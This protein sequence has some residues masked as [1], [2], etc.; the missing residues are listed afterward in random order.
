MQRADSRE[1]KGGRLFGDTMGSGGMLCATHN[2]EGRSKL[3]N[4]RHILI[5][6]ANSA[7]GRLDR[8][9][10]TLDQRWGDEPVCIVPY[11]GYGTRDCLFLKGRVLEDR[12][13]RPADETDS[14]WRNL[15]NMYRRF[16]SDEIPGARVLARIGSV[17]QIVVADDDGFFETRLVPNPPLPRDRLWHTIELVLLEPQPASESQIRVTGRVLVPPPNSRFG[18]ISDID[19]TVIQTNATSMVRM[20]RATFLENARTRL[21]FPG[22]AALYRA[23]QSG[24]AGATLNPLFYVSSSPWNMYDMLEEFFAI[25]RIPSGPLLLRDWGFSPLGSQSPLHH[26]KHKLETICQILDTYPALQF[27][28]IGDSG[29]ED[30]EIYREVVGRYPNRILAIYIRNVSRGAKRISAIQALAGEVAAAGSTLVLADETLA[31]AQH[32]A[33]QGWIAPQELDE[34]VAAIAADQGTARP[35][36]QASTIVVANQHDVQ[37]GTVKRV[38]EASQ[39]AERPPIV[40]VEGGK[41][42]Q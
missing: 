2:G 27:L 3:P 38:L 5:Q 13:I 28:L 14:A 35:T 19:D 25:Q 22:V 29:Q 15:R 34:L 21:P 32:A 20:L 36:E 9:K 33:R 26:R 7:E 10:R 17:E 37:V 6:L 4:W 24:T 18:V 31:A 40:I 12:G 1:P 11:Q 23:L 42:A 41:H 8:L 39:S 30:P 16:D